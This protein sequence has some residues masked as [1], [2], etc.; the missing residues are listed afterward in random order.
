MSDSSNSIDSLD[1]ATKEEAK[2]L[3]IARLKAA[4]DDL[5]IAIGSDEFS[6][7]ELLDHVSKTDRIGKEIM[8]IHLEYLRDMAKGAL[9]QEN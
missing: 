2:E 8:E 9:Y 1:E 6:K 5:N 4:S 7:E 3:A